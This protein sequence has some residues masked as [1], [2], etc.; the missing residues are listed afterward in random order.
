MPGDILGSLSGTAH[1]W[2]P[3]ALACPRGGYSY[4][5]LTSCVDLLYCI[6]CLS[7][8]TRFWV[9]RS[10][11]VCQS[12][13][14]PVWTGSQPSVLVLK[15]CLGAHAIHMSRPACNVQMHRHTGRQNSLTV[16]SARDDAMCTFSWPCL[17]SGCHA[18]HIDLCCKLRLSSA[19]PSAPPSL[20][21]SVKGSSSIVLS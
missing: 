19:T 6:V 7:A 10:V 18:S 8:H 9:R 1:G 12:A 20:P 2:L 13:S 11:P 17:I 3:H 21:P 5:Q 16:V 4:P 14:V 15:C